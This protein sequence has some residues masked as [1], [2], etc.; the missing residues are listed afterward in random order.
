M[1]GSDMNTLK[2]YFTTKLYPLQDGIL[3]IVKKSNTPFYLTGGTAL[4][5]GRYGH[6]FSEDLDLFVDNDPSYAA[7]VDA[8]FSLLK[9]HEGPDTFFLDQSRLRRSEYHTQLWVTRTIAGES[10]D[11]TRPRE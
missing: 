11:L 6:R 5:R 1:S 9:S 4:S 7:H 8:V 2:E 10:V 3:N